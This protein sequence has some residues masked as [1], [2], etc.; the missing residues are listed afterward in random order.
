V[1]HIDLLV[2]VIREAADI[3]EFVQVHDEV[4]QAVDDLSLLAVGHAQ[5]LLEDLDHAVECFVDRVEVHVGARVLVVCKLQQ[6]NC[7]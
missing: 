1:R 2:I 4:C 3:I 7:V 6:Q 5:L